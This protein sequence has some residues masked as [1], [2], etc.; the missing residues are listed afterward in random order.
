MDFTEWKA[1]LPY[2]FPE[3]KS[4]YIKLVLDRSLGITYFG[5]SPNKHET[6]T[7]YGMSAICF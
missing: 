5:I 3:T 1:E 6:N 7:F 2:Y 4:I